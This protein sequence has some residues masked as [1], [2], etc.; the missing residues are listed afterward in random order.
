[1]V[2]IYP[3]HYSKYQGIPIS[4]YCREVF[5]LSM[6]LTCGGGGGGTGL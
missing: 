5:V 3:A 4:Y 2:W 1:M 6:D